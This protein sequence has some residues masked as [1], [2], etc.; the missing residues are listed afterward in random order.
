MTGEAVFSAAVAMS[1]STRDFS[2][3]FL[4]LRTAACRIPFAVAARIQ[5][6]CAWQLSDALW[7]DSGL[8]HLSP[9]SVRSTSTSA[10]WQGAGA[11][12]ILMVYSRLISCPCVETTGLA[13][14][15]RA[16]SFDA[17]MGGY[18]RCRI[19]YCRL[20]SS[21]LDGL[22]SLSIKAG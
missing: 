4:Q 1:A 20:R 22:S 16:L 19:L 18:V 6:L 9:I 5:G 7:S 2:L 12:S 21:S 14:S 17:S 3:G 11:V 10:G 8:G 13:R 15:T